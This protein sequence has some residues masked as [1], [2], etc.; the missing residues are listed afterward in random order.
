MLRKCFSKEDAGQ[1]TRWAAGQLPFL[2]EVL[3]PIPAFHIFLTG[4]HIYI[5]DSPQCN[6]KAAPILMLH[7]SDICK[8]QLCLKVLGCMSHCASQDLRLLHSSLERLEN[9]YT[10]L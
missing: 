4:E 9:L 10:L 8:A 7:M 5:H 2:V 6:S 3:A 1:Q